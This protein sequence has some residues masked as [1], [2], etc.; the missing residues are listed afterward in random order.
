MKSSL[1]SND[2]SSASRKFIKLQFKK[3]IE[4]ELSR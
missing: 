2:I 4:D 3:E 1:I